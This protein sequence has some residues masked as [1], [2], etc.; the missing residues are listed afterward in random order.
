MGRRFAELTFTEAV[1]AEQVLHGSRR[2]YER[3]E[4]DGPAGDRLGDDE[5][6]FIA[7]RD[8]FYMAIETETGWPYV[9]HR[10]GHP[11]FLR[12]L[13]DRTVGFADLRGNRQYISV[14]SL[15]RND[16]VAMILMDYPAQSRLKLL[17]HASIYEGSAE[18]DRWLARL[19]DPAESAPAERAVV[20]AVEAFDWNCQQHITP[21]YTQE[22]LLPL[23]ERL[24]QLEEENRRLREALRST[25][26][27]P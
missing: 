6:S 25:G 16:R 24:R 15:R 19:V 10:G 20:I 8:S 21:R 1:Q 4:H 9:Q 22:Q 17:G 27:Q 3:V 12:V 5:K 23:R 2:Q 7:S 26:A 14:G 11:G 13:D 18:A